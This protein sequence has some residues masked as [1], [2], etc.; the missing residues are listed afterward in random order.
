MTDHLAVWA[1][2][3]LA[4]GL[5][6]ALRLIPLLGRRRRDSEISP[7]MDRFNRAFLACCIASMVVG[8]LFPGGFSSL[9]NGHRE[10]LI[11]AML[12]VYLVI[13]RFYTGLLLAPALALV[14]VAI[15]SIFF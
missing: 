5:T 1:A 3:C 7:T 12:A 13:S 15:R 14:F 11:V 2:I 6:L 9:T 8:M 4:G 10:V